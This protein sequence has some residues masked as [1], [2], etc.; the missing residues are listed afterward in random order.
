VRD[1]AATH[2]GTTGHR[3]PQRGGEPLGDRRTARIANV[4]R[5]PLQLID[6]N[7]MCP[8]PLMLA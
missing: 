7:R 6:E 2:A 1:G 3:H 4:G 8:Y 5:E